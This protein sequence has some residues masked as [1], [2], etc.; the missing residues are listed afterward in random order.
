MTTSM[1]AQTESRSN[2]APKVGICAYQSPD[3]LLTLD[4]VTDEFGLGRRA[5]V[6]A[7]VGVP[8]PAG[9]VSS[10]EAFPLT[11]LFGE[12]G[13]QVADTITGAVV[14]LAERAADGA[15]PSGRP[16]RQRSSRARGT[17]IARWKRS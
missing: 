2:R 14:L 10:C 6:K 7:L 13:R 4:A 9:A 16:A 15:S 8:P 12:D 11:V 5:L 1:A 3:A 17:R